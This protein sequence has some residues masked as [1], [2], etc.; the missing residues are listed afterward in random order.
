[1]K[2][3]PVASFPVAAPWSLAT[4]QA[5]KTLVIV[6]LCL[7]C[8][9]L[10]LSPLHKRLG[11]A[12]KTSVLAFIL[13]CFALFGA[14]GCLAT[15][16]ANDQFQFSYVFAHGDVH[17]TLQYKIAGVWSGQQG[18]FL[19]WAI[20]SAV[21]GLLTLRSVGPYRPAYL[22]VYSG[23]LATL[24]GILAYETPFGI[25]DAVNLGGKVFVPPSG[26]GLA[27]SLMNYWV[28]IHPP[29]IFTGFGSLTVLFA[30]AVAAIL[31]KDVTD[32][33]P[34]VRPWAL[35]SVAILGLGIC[36]GGFWAYETLGWGGFWAWDPVENASFIPW[37]FAVA[38]VHGAMVQA[39]KK[40]WHGS[41][42]WFGALP[43]LTFCYGTFL[44]RGGY[45][46]KVSVH[47]FA[48][49][50]KSALTILKIFLALVLLGYLGL[51]LWKG[52][53]LAKAFASPTEG[54]P[55]IERE[56]LYRSGVVLL[57]LLG[58]V[59]S[60]GMSWPLIM[61]L[62]GRATA[63]VE[64]G[65]YHKVVVWLFLPLMILVAVAPFV[66]WRPMTRKEV[67]AKVVNAFTLSVAVTGV[68]MLLLRI[69]SWGVN[70]SAGATVSTPFNF[71]IPAVPW[72]AVLLLVCVFAFVS[73]AWRAIEMARKNQ[74]S[75]G[76]FVAHIGL[77][78]LFGGLILS[79]GLEQKEQAFVRAD[80]PVENV[81][82]YKI[83]YAGMT[84]DDLY[85]RDGKAKFEITPPD[86]KTFTAT[87]G[88]YYMKNQDAD[89]DKAMQWPYIRR[90]GA[91]DLYLALGAPILTVWEKPV[92]FHKGQTQ[93]VSGLTVTYKG[94]TIEGQPGTPS[95]SFGANL[96]VSVVGSDSGFATGEYDV[97][98]HFTVANGPDLPK[99][100]PDFRVA[101]SR[102]NA[103]DQSAEVQ[104][105]FAVPIYPIELFTKPLTVLVWS[106]TAIMT[107]GGFMA[108]YSRR[109]P[110]SPAQWTHDLP[111]KS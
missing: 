21:F 69:P 79:R 68:T 65:L 70:A 109:R 10:I 101:L 102:I 14:F 107:L 91:H 92:W 61:S 27:P 30:L 39:A 6:G 17:T 64:E 22:A 19:L 74:I 41:N 85:N 80:R 8:L 42:L 58:A 1:M 86:G 28:V 3:N 15:L 55:G 73:N 78:T 13:G 106:G 60:L 31:H 110:K 51:Y 88:L 11:F 63:K 44:T 75:L 87:P 77:A 108:A 45:L 4:G 76:G 94:L 16:F 34:I 38:L 111:P 97:T 2:D 53:P 93:T 26:Q 54:V 56:A 96:H 20:T 7:F 81:L 25:L 84:S 49:M 18:S 82:G 66:G 103:A 32:W 43:F 9:A 48:S 50:D 71:R 40:K 83:R 23:F 47:S 67:G 104:M 33:M 72:V 95:A 100:S 5:G 35:G 99:F 52:R 37:L 90:E 57:T 46:D 24:C 62:M 29:T 59:L 12:S 89:E 98:P 36:M 105:Y